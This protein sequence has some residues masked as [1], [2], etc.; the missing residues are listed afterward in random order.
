MAATART[1]GWRSNPGGTAVTPSAAPGTR[2]ASV[3][4]GRLRLAVLLAAGMLVASCGASIT[5][6]AGATASPS[7]ASSPTPSVAYAPGG[8]VASAADALQ[9]QFVSVIRQVNPSV[10]LIQ[11][12]GGLGSGVVFDTRGDIVTNAHVAGS[13]TSFTVTL[14]NGRNVPG[15]LV[16]TFAPNDI[17]VIRAAA[18]NLQPARFTGS[19]SLHVG[20]IVLAMGNPLG[21]QSSVTEG[22]VSALGRTVPEPNGAALP[23][24]IQTSASINPGNSGGALVDLNG[25]VVGIPTLAASDPQLGGAAAGIGFAIPSS[26]A[27]DL[28]TQI[29]T[30]GHVIDSH[31]A[32]LG[33]EAA[34]LSTGIPGGGA[35]VY[36]VVPGGPASKAGLT[37]GDIIVAVNGQATPSAGGLAA[38]LANLKPAQT[39]PVTVVR[40][41]GSR[42]TV[43]VTLGQLPG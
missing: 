36:S 23:D 43:S 19:S 8:S 1:R 24:V 41:D 22:I 42:S 15:T 4:R 11:T 12:S 13:A 9:S 32:Y 27:R 40:P 3:R 2:S 18:S 34:D 26:I 14:A 39:V 38:V 30:Y 21:L 6:S 16:G 33:I 35:L 29:I 5:P 10:V 28:A 7:A 31:R 20:D 17:A 25:D 37:S